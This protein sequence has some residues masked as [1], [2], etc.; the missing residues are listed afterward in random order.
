[1]NDYDDP[2]TATLT[3][4]PAANTLTINKHS[5]SIFVFSGTA[6]WKGS[7]RGGPVFLGCN[8]RRYCCVVDGV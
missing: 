2:P 5:F 7:G 1:M 3:A 4:Q 8:H 6:G